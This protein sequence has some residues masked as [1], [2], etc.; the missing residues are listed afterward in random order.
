M[1]RDLPLRVRYS[2]NQNIAA[3]FFV[4]CLDASTTYDRA[5]GYFSSTFYAI[6]NLPL[7][8]FAD[9]GGKIRLVCS[10]ELSSQDIEAIGAGYADKTLNDALE[11]DIDATAKEPVADAA[12]K[13]VATLIAAGVLE[14]RIAF[15]R[16]EIGIFHDKT[17]IFTS[18]DGDRVSFT[19]SANETWSAWSGRA[20]YEGF[21]AHRSWAGTESAEHVDADV[22]YF[23]RVWNNTQSDLDVVP[24]PEIAH[25]RLV[26]KADPDGI[27][28][29]QLEL[30]RLIVNRPP[31]PKLREHQADAITNW[32]AVG[33]RGLFEHATGSGKTITTL[34]CIDLAVQ[35]RRP[36][37]IVVPS[38]LLLHQWKDEIRTFFGDEVA[39]LLAGDGNDQWKTGSLL[40]DHLT[41]FDE[42]SPIVLAT[43]DTACSP[44]FVDRLD[45]INRL[46]L[47]ADEVHRVGSPD[48]RRL[49]EINADW[50][51]GVSA[52]WEREG[53]HDGT[54]T[55]LEYFGEVIDPIYTLAD[56][57]ADAHLCNYRYF[58]HPVALD[59]DERTEWEGLRTRIG[60]AIARAGGEI[61][62]DVQ[63]LLIQRARIVKSARAKTAVAVQILLD[64]YQDGQAW[65]VY[66]D[67]KDQVAVVREA[68]TASGIRTQEYHTQMEGDSEAAL[69]D[70]VM[71]GGV[72]VAIN[73]L[74]EGIDIPRISHALVLA[75]STTRRQFIQ[76]RG[77]VL[78]QHETKHRA[79]IHDLLVDAS[80]FD[81]P[82]NVS[83]MRSEL[84]RALEFVTPAVDSDATEIQIREM[85]MQ[86]HV[87]IDST[88][89]G[90]GVEDPT[91]DTETDG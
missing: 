67:N 54:Q 62:E 17:G 1:L 22:E 73:C 70:F 41:E 86:A 52:T 91:E 90:V 77:R 16:N 28:S 84:A 19:G 79:E 18:A 29:A 5:V 30:D 2:S 38:R 27:E 87:D 12:T 55:L 44:R 8:R 46:F 6:I 34:S 15:K 47:A 74:D 64:R 14:I 50:R 10:P 42:Q 40:R 43:V 85:A 20:N 65:L 71:D 33:H 58:V 49:L 68:C 75:S 7:A 45:G 13:L 80:G 37:L 4:P 21:H 63:R 57:I 83:F 72:M 9:R 11:R 56:A 31:R 48:R 81:D 69:R 89:A 82:E 25:E 76:R 3:D 39:V 51:L 32:Q 88:D 23:E 26:A 36:T 66:C 35:D 78:R 24:F 61:H 53:D 59:E 60:R